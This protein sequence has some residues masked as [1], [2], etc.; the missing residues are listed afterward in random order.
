MTDPIST[1]IKSISDSVGKVSGLVKKYND[2]PLM[3]E[4]IELKTRVFALQ[5]ELL[6]AK[7]E[8][9]QRD[10]M[11]VDGPHGYCFK[12]GDDKPYCPTCWQGSHKEVNLP[13][14]DNYAGGYGR[15]CRVCKQLYV[16]RKATLQ[17][18]LSPHVSQ[19][20]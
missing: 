19:W 9:A 18:Q 6:T 3:E 17:R 7:I 14:P 12:A 20:G 16:E 4:I 8:L 15:V 2:L 1:T 13:P 11:R 5:E 10:E